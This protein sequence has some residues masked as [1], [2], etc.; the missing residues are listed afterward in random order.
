MP[1]STISSER[2]RVLLVDD[3]EAML[4]RTAAVL[5]AA[6]TVVAA[7]TD[8]R[9]A[10]EAASRLRPDVIV[11]DISMTEMTGFE[12]AARLRAAGSSAAVVFFTVHEDE[13]FLTAARAAGGIGYVIKPRLTSDLVPAVREARAGRSFVSTI[14]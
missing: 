1:S 9:A 3:N 11:L 14:R 13:A 4:A 7:V 8:G 6:C 5:T 12:V 2:P 10:L